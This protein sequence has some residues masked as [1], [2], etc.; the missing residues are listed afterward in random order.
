MDIESRWNSCIYDLLTATKVQVS[1]R[2]IFD[3]F[4]LIFWQLIANFTSLKEQ[5]QATH[6]SPTFVQCLPLSIDITYAQASFSSSRMLFD[7]LSNRNSIVK[8]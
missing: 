3:D 7:A 8:D 5:A 1:S 2:L 6:S 4:K